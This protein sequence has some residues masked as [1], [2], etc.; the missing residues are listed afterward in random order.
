MTRAWLVAGMAALSATADADALHSTREQP[1]VE[2]SHTVD[3]RINDGVATYAVR[4]QFA[5]PGKIAD[6]A[7]LAIDLPYGAAAT[8]LRIRAHD[9]WYDGELMERERAAAL[10][11]ELT[12]QGAYRPKDP[13]L[14]QWLWADKL[15]LQVFPVL[16]G[17]VST[18]EYT[19]T[20]PTRYA[21]GRYVLS[22]PLADASRS[23]STDGDGKTLQLATPIVT[24][25]PGWGDSSTPIT[26]DGKRVAA[27]TP[28]VLEPPPRTAWQ[29]VVGGNASYVSSAIAVPASSHTTKTFTRATVRLDIRHTYKSDLVVELVTPDGGQVKLHDRAGGG[30]NDLTG[31]LD[32]DL[33]A[34]THGAGTWRLVV[35]DHAALDTGTI[36]GWQLS[37][38]DTTARA[39]DTPVFIPDAPETDSDAGV[40]TIAIAPPAMTIWTARLGAVVASTEHAFTRLEI[41]TPAQLA[42]LPERAQVVF[43]IDAS[44]SMTDEGVAAQL[45]V[46]RAY[47]SHV[48]D[49]EIEIVTY[50][51]HATRVFGELVPATK[52]E[53]AIAAA[54]RRGA[55]ALRNGSAADE[56]ARLAAS[57]LQTRTGPRRLVLATDDLVRPS[58]DEAVQRKA[59]AAS[60]RDAVVHVIVPSLDR[61]DRTSL[62]RDDTTALA[63]LAIYHHGISARITGLPM[64]GLKELAP[65]V[66]ELVRP[67]RI[68]KLEV[69]GIKLDDTVLHEGDGVRLMKLD[70]TAPSRVMLTGRIWSDPVQREL[71]AGEAFSRQTAGFVFG[72]DLYGEL[73]VDEQMRVAMRGHAVSPV[74]SFVAFEPGTRPSEIGLDDANGYGGLLGNEAGEMSSGYGDGASS[75]RP[76]L[77]YL[78]DT[79]PCVAKG[80]PRGPWRV[81]FSVETTKDEIVDVAITSGASDP[82]AACLVEA[83]WATRLDAA[84][85]RDHDTFK[86][87]LHD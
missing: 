25:H 44:Y 61:D 22:Y 39:T 60:P 65:P 1:L 8:G 72:G 15:Y 69:T 79:E 51:R 11:H 43:A 37:I 87:D 20:V 4:R 54:T 18:V 49:A 28:V 31:T 46:L 58:L 70:A 36:D 81:G 3:I 10:Y 14:L 19:L 56:A 83:V 47:A 85:Y 74:T 34:G 48:P 71:V 50:N 26:I 45:D 27:G 29:E 6:Q 7:G 63:P 52:L 62:T 35:S 53:A 66:L 9:V 33:P 24:V 82:M 76:R 86:F 12:G 16:P 73:S 5:N 21:G 13:A 30:D 80:K 75:V 40:A 78:V 42:P 84:Y 64:R 32:V 38:G 77:D 67:T 59:L 55:F 68:E 2:V 17:Q 41:D 57:I 23:K